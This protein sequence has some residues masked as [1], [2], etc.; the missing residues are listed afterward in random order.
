MPWT[1]CWMTTKLK[2][3][4]SVRSRKKYGPSVFGE[5][6]DISQGGLGFSNDLVLRNRLCGGF[7]ESLGRA[8][9]GVFLFKF[10]YKAQG[11]KGTGG[12]VCITTDKLHKIVEEAPKP[13]R[14]QEDVSA[15]ED[16][17]EKTMT[18]VLGKGNV[19]DTDDEGSCDSLASS[20]SC[21]SLA[22]DQV[23]DKKL[24]AKGL[25]DLDSVL[26]G[27]K[28]AATG[29][30]ARAAETKPRRTGLEPLWSDNYF[31]IPDNDPSEGK[32]II[33]IRKNYTVPRPDGLGKVNMSKQVTPAQFGWKREEP[34]KS[35]LLLRAWAH[36]RGHQLGWATAKPFRKREFDEN[37]QLLEEE[38]RALGHEDRLLGDPKANALLLHWAPRM[39]K[40]LRAPA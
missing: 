24:K 30:K 2:T 16:S 18:E 12:G 8:S 19:V 36:W 29:A 39:V 37:E 25:K 4:T 7:S 9:L 1:I 10:L 11:C 23:F 22:S 20:S 17:E 15:S 13:K 26:A 21:E 34:T 27:D 14:Q 31:V 33:H 5:A 35:V 28:D 6:W 32:L 38:I 40:R 3:R